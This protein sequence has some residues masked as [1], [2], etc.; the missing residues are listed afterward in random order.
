MRD[1]GKMATGY[2]LLRLSWGKSWGE[3]NEKRV[4]HQDKE[5]RAQ[6]KYKSKERE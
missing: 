5:T 6:E 3:A 4:D 1:L 2:G